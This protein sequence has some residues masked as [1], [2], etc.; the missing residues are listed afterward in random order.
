MKPIQ[1]RSW[2]SG[3][4]SFILCCSVLLLTIPLSFVVASEVD[5]RTDAQMICVVL[6]LFSL[7]IPAVFM[8]ALSLFHFQK[9]FVM[10]NNAVYVYVPWHIKKELPIEDIRAFG[11]ACFAPRSSRLYLCCAPKERIMQFYYAHQSECKRLFRNLSYERLC[12]TE[13]GIWMMA[14]GVYVYLKQHDIYFLDYGN[15]KRVT[16]LE[17][18]IGKSATNI[19]IC[20]CTAQNTLF[21][22]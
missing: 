22:N 10:T 20:Q 19:D 18:A 13:D 6:T 4:I 21:Q 12:Q 16:F 5:I 1:I 2:S 7:I 15:Q 17:T 3:T 9:R 11:L 14:V 8:V